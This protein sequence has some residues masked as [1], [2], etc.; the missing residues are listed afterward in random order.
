M[1][2]D[3]MIPSIIV[4]GERFIFLRKPKLNKR[5]YYYNLRNLKVDKLI[6]SFFIMYLRFFVLFNIVLLKIIIKMLPPVV[7]KDMIR[8]D[9][10]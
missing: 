6:F 9:R 3:L 10:H 4:N 7:I 1:F 5:K 2:L 8:S